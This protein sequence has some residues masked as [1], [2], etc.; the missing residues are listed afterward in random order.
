MGRGRS[1]RHIAL[2]ERG[3]EFYKSVRDKKDGC[4]FWIALHRPEE[5]G[6]RVTTV[7]FAEAIGICAS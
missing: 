3:P 6:G 2:R 1:P 7:Q 5:P 4:A